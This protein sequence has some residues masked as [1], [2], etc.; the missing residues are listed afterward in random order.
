MQLRVPQL[1]GSLTIAPGTRRPNSDKVRIANANPLNQALLLA[2]T[3]NYES[4]CTKLPT[5]GD[6]GVGEASCCG[7]ADGAAR[8]P[9]AP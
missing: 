1:P 7:H 8:R 3:C 5:S 4:L 2:T 9:R 6:G